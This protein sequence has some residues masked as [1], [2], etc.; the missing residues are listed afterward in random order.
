MQE[1]KEW[2]FNNKYTSDVMMEI[3]KRLV[4]S[5]KKEKKYE[6]IHFWWGLTTLLCLLLAGCYV[7]WSKLMVTNTF[8]T[9]LQALT[10][11]IFFMV[12]VIIIVLCLLQLKYSKKKFE[13]AE[14]E[15]ESLRME[16]IERTVELWEN[17]EHWKNRHKVFEVME[18]EY[19]I[20]LYHK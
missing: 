17:E 19:D 9:S 5:K 1:F 4:E 16:V 13:K 10:S 2:K 15:F 11:D 18:K 6:T 8:I 14:K 20:N 3:L 12:F 7:Y